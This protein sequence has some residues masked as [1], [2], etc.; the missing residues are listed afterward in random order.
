M[1]EK[2][3]VEYR[4]KKTKE[5]EQAKELQDKMKELGKDSG[6]QLKEHL[7][8]FNDAVIAIISTIMVLEIPLPT[9]PDVSYTSFIR[10]IIIFF[11]SFFM[12]SNF[13][14]QNHGYMILIEKV[15]KSFVVL[16]F[17]FLAVL[18][19]MPIMTKWLMQ[20]HSALAVVNMGVVYLLVNMINVLLLSKIYRQIFN[21]SEFAAMF[22]QRM[23][24]FQL[25]FIF[26]LNI[27]L[28]FVAFKFPTV[29]MIFYLALPILSF[30][31]PS[32]R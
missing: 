24:I 7:S 26:G 25:C 12:V 2:R 13:W 10:A 3:N 5:Y 11:I 8:V 21:T 32:Q 16:N 14:Y 1:N 29:A 9:E 23:I 15:D 20:E 31:M 30:I 19:L 4:R 6:R 27:L 28:I 22:S 18:S 17:F